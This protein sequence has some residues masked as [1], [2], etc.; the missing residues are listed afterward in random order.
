MNSGSS[1]PHEA[2]SQAPAAMVS[3]LLTL[4]RELRNMVYPHLSHPVEFDWR[5]LIDRDYFLPFKREGEVRLRYHTAQVRFDAAS[6]ADV[7]ATHSRL[8][9]E[10]LEDTIIA[11]LSVPVTIEMYRC[12]TTL[13]ELQP[14]EILDQRAKAAFANVKHATLYFKF[15]D[16]KSY[17]MPDP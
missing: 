7:L 10:Y 13:T 8:R 6:D 1:Q 16:G 4:P 12:D 14:G 2:P 9:E 17:C 11:D 3:H 5:W 15:V